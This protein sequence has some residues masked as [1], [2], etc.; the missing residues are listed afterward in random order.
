MGALAKIN[1]W[2]KGES[3]K[4]ILAKYSGEPIWQT[5]EKVMMKMKDF[6]KNNGWIFFDKEAVAVLES[7]RKEFEK[8]SE[9]IILMGDE[10]KKKAHNELEEKINREIDRKSL[11]L[12]LL[13]MQNE[14]HTIK[15]LAELNKNK[16]K[17]VVVDK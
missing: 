13:S 12:Q 1:Q 17:Y 8:K 16:T 15:K 2:R 6:Y 4:D 10:A 7:M 5:M 11:K 9:Q 3:K 14:Y